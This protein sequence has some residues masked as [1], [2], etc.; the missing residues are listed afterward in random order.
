LVVRALTYPRVARS[1]E[2]TNVVGASC[3]D[4]MGTQAVRLS[5]RE[6]EVA[7]LVAEGLTNR[8]IATR[9]FISERTVES[10][11][12]RIRRKLG[13]HHRSEI[14]AWITRGTARPSGSAAGESQPAA[15]AADD[16]DHL[17]DERQRRAD[18]REQ[19]ADGR[20]ARADQREATLDE[21][22]R[23]LERREMRTDRR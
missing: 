1:P 22:E 20:E 12:E 2:I 13:F 7:R 11:L 21:R 9:L 5:P 17:A 3:T 14:A 23:L 6:G 16:R 10:H 18:M 4:R 19:G 8:E 15:N